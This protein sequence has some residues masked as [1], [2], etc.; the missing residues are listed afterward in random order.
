VNSMLTRRGLLTASTVVATGHA[1]AQ[2]GKPALLGGNPAH[3]GAFPAWPVFD[4]REE[5]ALLDTLATRKWLRISGQNVNRFEEAYAR[6]LGSKGC[7][8]TSNGTS[9]LYVS[10]KALGVGPGDEVI[11]PPYTFVATINA[12]LLLYALPVFVDTDPETGQIDARK[13]EAAITDRTAAIL[14]VHL[15]GSAADLDTILAIAQRHHLPVVEDAC[16]AHLGEWRNRKLGT[17]GMT[18]CF[19]FQATKNM[20]CGEG[21]ALVTDDPALLEKCF[22]I[23]SH[24][25]PRTIS[26]YDFAYRAIGGANLRMDEFHAALA[27]IQ[28][29]RLPQQ[30]EIRDRNAS[31]L[32]SLL[33]DIPGIRPLRMYR[34]C[35]RNAWHLYMLHYQPEAFAGMSKRQFLWALT[36]EGIRGAAGYTPLNKEPFLQNTFA[37]RDF[38]AVFSKARMARWMECN[39]CPVNEKFCEETVWL[40]QSMLLAGRTDMEQIAEA[41]RKIQAHA[42]ELVKV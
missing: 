13:I 6:M 35:T 10:L 36:A 18:G 11:V 8:A 26:G 33:R 32:T 24:G 30:A 42:A 2:I 39:Q 20:A 31:Y 15:G 1:A 41:I 21:G 22:V 5:Q 28:M 29:T 16:Q 17:Y 23:H 12:V 37:G 14:P 3:P 40:T 9:A 27:S 34:G 25:R 19:S 38:Q 4:H 7:L